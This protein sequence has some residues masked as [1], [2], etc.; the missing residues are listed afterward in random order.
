MVTII[1]VLGG[2]AAGGL[3]EA[4]AGGEVVEGAGSTADD[5]P[6]QLTEGVVAVRDGSGGD[7]GILLSEVAVG[8]VGIGGGAGGAAL[9]L[10]LGGELVG[11][12]VGIGGGVGL[13]SGG[14]QGGAVAVVIISVGVLLADSPGR[15][16]LDAL[17]GEAAKII[18]GV[19]STLKSFVAG[20]GA[21]QCPLYP[22]CH[23]AQ[24]WQLIN[25]SNI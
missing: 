10:G 8:V 18:V 20:E 2:H 22:Q 16:E 9:G 5:S 21:E 23:D 19:K 14:S 24:S 17:A 4:Q 3:G 15:C 13:G 25:D 7:A 1:E 6:V 12:V 11:L